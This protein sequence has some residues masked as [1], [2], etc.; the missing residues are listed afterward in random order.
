MLSFAFHTIRVLCCMPLLHLASSVPA[1]SCSLRV[2]WRPPKMKAGC[3]WSKRLSKGDPKLSRCA[4][5]VVGVDVTLPRVKVWDRSCSLCSGKNI[6][7]LSYKTF[8]FE[9]TLMKLWVANASLS[10]HWSERR[11]T[12]ISALEWL[13]KQVL[14]RRV[15]EVRL[16]S[17]SS[18][19]ETARESRAAR[20]MPK[21]SR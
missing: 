14:R 1:T 3:Q 2:Q 19:F 4:L 15:S 6:Q 5:T 11:E 10:R 16:Q 7:R 17:R 18:F 20:N 9:L 21:H 12:G 13:L 8:W